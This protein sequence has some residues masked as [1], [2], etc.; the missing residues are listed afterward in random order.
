MS[1]IRVRVGNIRKALARCC[2]Y[3]RAIGIGLWGSRAVLTRTASIALRVLSDAAYRR[4]ECDRWREIRDVF[5]R[6]TRICFRMRHRPHA[7]V[8]NER[9]ANT[10]DSYLGSAV[11]TPYFARLG[12][13]C[14]FHMNASRTSCGTAYT[15]SPSGRTC[16]S[17]GRSVLGRAMSCSLS[18]IASRPLCERDTDR[19]EYR[20]ARR[21]AW[22]S[23][24]LSL[25]FDYFT[26]R[27]TPCRW[28]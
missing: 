9:R 6:S 27:L 23:L 15:S 28:T 8:E 25:A 17:D 24:V 13:F 12:A 4:R 10:A 11:P 16:R 21:N 18:N 22:R 1:L 3:G 2:S 5:H 20:N 26:L 14:V 7:A 19:A